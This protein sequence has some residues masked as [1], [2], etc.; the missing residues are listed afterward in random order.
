[1]S[2]WNIEKRRR[3]EIIEI[4]EILS[5]EEEGPA[6]FPAME[7]LDTKGR[8]HSLAACDFPSFEWNKIQAGSKIMLILMESVVNTRIISEQSGT[9]L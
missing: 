2:D 7:V 6:G 9:P 8:K 4:K 3:I 1:M 5:R